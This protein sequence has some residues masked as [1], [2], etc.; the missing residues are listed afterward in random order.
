MRSGPSNISNC[1]PSLKP[2]R[3]RIAALGVATDVLLGAGAVG[4][5][6]GITYRV[7]IGGGEGSDARPGHAFGMVATVSM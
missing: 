6:A 4:V 2:A 5:A 1:D 3:D 7:M